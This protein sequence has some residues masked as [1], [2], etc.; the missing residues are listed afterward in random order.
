MSI[1]ERFKLL[2]KKGRIAVVVSLLYLVGVLVA[3][4]AFANSFSKAMVGL[5]MYLS[6]L[7]LYWGYKAITAR[8]PT[9]AQPSKAASQ[10]DLYAEL[11]KLGDLKDRGILTEEEFLEQ[12]KVILDRH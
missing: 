10:P 12:K 9:A 1:W 5:G 6:P 11:T 4:V 7:A 8:P 3:M 2:D